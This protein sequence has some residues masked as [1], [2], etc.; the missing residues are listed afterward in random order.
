[1]RPKWAKRTCAPPPNGC[2]GCCA[3][4][5]IRQIKEPDQGHVPGP[6]IPAAPKMRARGT[7]RARI[8][9]RIAPPGAQ[10]ET[11]V[12]MA[13]RALPVGGG[14]RH[15]VSRRGGDVGPSR[16]EVAWG[17][18]RRTG[19]DWER[20]PSRRLDAFAA[21]P[22][23]AVRSVRSPRPKW[24]VKRHRYKP[25]FWILRSYVNVTTLQPPVQNDEDHPVSHKLAGLPP[26]WQIS[27]IILGLFCG[28][29]MRSVP[30]TAM[31]ELR[32]HEV[33]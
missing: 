28:R 31:N 19:G 33:R 11:N 25:H 24:L 4:V 17:R 1:M 27:S 16:G 12:P 26:R 5:R 13:G 15:G 3:R 23:A 7:A 18:G 30:A 10:G 20:Q 21:L 6:A 2:G 9:G 8:T 29:I 14:G 32:L 22:K